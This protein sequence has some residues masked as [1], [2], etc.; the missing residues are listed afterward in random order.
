MISEYYAKLG[1]SSNASQAEIKS[2]YRKLVKLIHPDVNPA[3]DA[4]KRFIEITE[5]Y[6]I[7]LGE[8]KAPYQGFQEIFQEPVQPTFDPKEAWR[9]KK[10]KERFQREKKEKDAAIK[11]D[12]AYFRR[13]HY[14]I[15]VCVFIN[16]IVLLDST[17]G[18]KSE[19][20]LLNNAYISL[21]APL[22]VIIMFEIYELLTT[23]YFKEKLIRF[24]ILLTILEFVFL[25]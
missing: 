12:E 18:E 15:L 22:V 19:I 8:R 17:S 7:L 21:F 1:L 24:I 9:I 4:A 16:I 5:A 20:I 6:E 2:A 13:M 10:R 11:K 3:P 23:G 14:P 25:L